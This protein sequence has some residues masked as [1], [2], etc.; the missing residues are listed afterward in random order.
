[1][2][3]V[4]TLLF[5]FGII[6]SANSQKYTTT[7]EDVITHREGGYFATVRVKVVY[8]AFM[9]EPTIK[10]I[11]KVIEHSPEIEVGTL[12][13]QV[14][15]KQGPVRIASPTFTNLIGFDVAGSPDW[16]ELWSGVSAERAKEIYKQGFQITN[17]RLYNVT[18]RKSEAQKEKERAEKEAQAQREKEEAEAKK[19]EEAERAKAEAE[20]QKREEEAQKQ[21]EA[22]AKQRE[23]EEAAAEREQEEQAQREREE[24]Q[25][26]QEAAAKAE[27][28]RRAANKQR[29]EEYQRRKQ[30]QLDRNTETAGYAAAS[31]A[32]LLITLGTLIY[33]NMGKVSASQTYFPNRFFG[34]INL[35]YSSGC[36]P[37]MFNSEYYDE[38]YNEFSGDVIVID[39]KETEP[40]VVIPISLDIEPYFGFE[41]KYMNIVAGG[42]IKPGGSIIFNAY[43]LNRSIYGRAAAGIP[44]LKFQYGYARGVRQYGK[45]YWILP[46][47]FGSGKAQYSYRTH[48][49]ALRISFEG[50]SR[51][52]SRYH[53]VAGM[54]LEN[55]LEGTG[56]NGSQMRYRYYQLDPALSGEPKKQLRL[57]GFNFQLIKEHTYVFYLTA[58]PRYPYVGTKDFKY[59]SEFG[60]KENGLPLIEV[61][62]V[63]QIKA[64]I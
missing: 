40:D 2:K 34:G 35:G 3:T 16:D 4:Y 62:F 60:E 17:G 43:S 25:A 7:Y 52:Y 45:N 46:S 22:E 6:C 51:I 10:A 37:L 50:N 20:E 1:M 61:G 53:L 27:Q 39:S 19:A 11:A 13:L 33:D 54:T 31:S 29:V 5:V 41:N 64:F 44:N 18:F 38:I 49:L 14:D 63:R 30:E 26:R 47:E 32:S 36:Y 12:H 21:K 15:I 23:Q 48:E 42:S 8:D 9:G 59:A 55:I 24:E 56:E 57:T 28:E 58:Y